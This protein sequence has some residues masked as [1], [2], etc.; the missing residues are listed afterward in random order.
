MLI[1]S[2]IAKVLRTSLSSTITNLIVAG[3]ATCRAS[4]KSK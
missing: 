3:R 1:E 2:S 4:A